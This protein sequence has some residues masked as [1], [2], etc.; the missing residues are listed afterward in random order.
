MRYDAAMANT[1]NPHERVA[2]LLAR[3]LTLRQIA[4]QAG[5]GLG[6]VAE[7]ATGKTQRPSYSTALLIGNVRV[8][9]AQKAKCPKTTNCEDANENCA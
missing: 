1:P 5:V 7:I 4:R 8:P 3:G 2:L 9:R 6:T